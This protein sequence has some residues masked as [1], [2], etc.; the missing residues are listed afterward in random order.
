MKKYIPYIIFA[1]IFYLLFDISETRRHVDRRLKHRIEQLESAQAFLPKN[2][3]WLNPSDKGFSL[4]M[5]NIGFYFVNCDNIKNYGDDKYELVLNI[6][7]LQSVVM[8]NI[9]LKIFSI[10]G[11]IDEYIINELPPGKIQ[12]QKI[13]LKKQKEVTL[14]RVELIASAV[15]EGK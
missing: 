15:T 2:Y 5:S 3:Q 8:K 12:R 7:N 14:F 4:H 13:F 11:N 1:I 9:K 6:C 10:D